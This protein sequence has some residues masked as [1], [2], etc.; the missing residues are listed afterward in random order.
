MLDY[1]NREESCHLWNWRHRAIGSFL[2]DH[3]SLYT[4]AAFCADGAFIESQQFS[5]AASVP[6]DE[7]VE[8]YPPDRFDMFVALNTAVS[9]RRAPQSITRRNLKAI[10]SSVTFARVPCFERLEHWRQLLH[11]RESDHPAV[12]QNWKQCDDVERKPYRHNSTIGDHCFPYIT[13]RRVQPR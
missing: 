8:K 10:G 5:R 1:E 12:C 9:T 4:V 2:F 6:F 3:D 11:F 7:V 13:C